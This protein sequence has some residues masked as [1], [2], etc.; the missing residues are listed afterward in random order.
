LLA[1]G[2]LARAVFTLLLGPHHGFFPRA[3]LGLLARTLGSQGHL[4]RFLFRA[5]A[6]LALGS[7]HCRARLF[8]HAEAAFLFLEG[9]A[10]RFLARRELL[11]DLD[12]G[13]RQR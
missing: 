4:A 3:L 1:L 11:L 2:L 5:L 6:R 13:K 12:L 10:N 7:V 9:L 8:L